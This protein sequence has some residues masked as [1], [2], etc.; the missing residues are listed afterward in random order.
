VKGQPAQA[1]S[2][3][4]NHLR[5]EREAARLLGLA[6]VPP[7]SVRVMSTP[8]HLSGPLARPIVATQVDRAVFWR[9]PMGFDA[10]LAWLRAHAPAGLTPNGHIGQA[11][12]PGFR[13]GGNSYAEP[14]RNGITGL[15]L[16]FMQAT[17]ADAGHTALRVDALAIWRDPAPLRDTL[18]GRRLRVD[19]AHGCPASDLRRVGV[20]SSGADLARELLPAGKPTGALV[21]RYSGLNDHPTF[22]LRT[23]IRLGSARAADLA[24][25][26]RRV[27]LSHEGGVVT[28]C[29]MDDDSVTVLAFSYP[30]RPDV[31]LWL[32]ARGCSTVSN[33]VIVAGAWGLDNHVPGGGPTR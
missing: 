15:Q 16:Q 31:D 29:P 27:D 1:A 2:A 21:C 32:H 3:Q 17:T 25:L 26:I 13:I 8:A 5:A 12:G 22:A 23:H 24:S 30:G 14:A 20:T 11:G 19:I 33:G 28:S 7:G 6:E 10:T 18:A 4:A 9:V